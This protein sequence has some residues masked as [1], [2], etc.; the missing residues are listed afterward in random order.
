MSELAASAVRAICPRC[1]RPVRS[2]VEL[3]TDLGELSAQLD[4]ARRLALV[5]ANPE[6]AS[7]AR[8][9]LADAGAK[10]A[11]IRAEA[12]GEHLACDPAGVVV[13]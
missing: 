8:F 12:A 11:V 13:H 4:A 10:L 9:A 6:A 3:N 7:V 2:G 1:N 5:P